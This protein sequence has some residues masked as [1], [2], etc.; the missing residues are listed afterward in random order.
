VCG[1]CGIYAPGNIDPELLRRMND[2]IVHRGPDDEG[3][4]TD[5]RVGLASRRLAIIDL[6]LGRMPIHNEDESVWVVFNGEIYNFQELR[7]DLIKRGHTFVTNTDTETLV[8]LYEER[9]TDM[10]AALRGM[11]AIALW[12]RKRDVLLLADH[13]LGKLA[14]EFSK[15]ALS[16]SP[17]CQQLLLS[18]SWPGNVRELSNAIE[19]AVILAESQTLGPED[20][21]LGFLSSTSGAA[22]PSGFELTGSLFDT[23][24]RAV[25]AVER[26][27]ITQALEESRGNRALAAEKLNISSKTLLAKLRALGLDS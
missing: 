1:I 19:R 18:Y 9:G 4:Y 11:F 21:V 27:K 6:S 14:R 13:F 5:E 25:R 20:L 8:H 16:L 15:P 23:T 7:A 24:E 2:T 22:P 26:A 17:A 12:D 10:F 3:Y